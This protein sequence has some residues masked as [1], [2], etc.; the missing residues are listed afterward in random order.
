MT[1]E[2]TTTSGF[3]GR[4]PMTDAERD[5]SVARIR[6]R[7]EA[8]RQ[9]RDWGKVYNALLSQT[10]QRYYADTYETGGSDG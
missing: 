6:A 3:D 4:R 5:R 2:Q 8:Q 10:Q 7:A 9:A 1:S